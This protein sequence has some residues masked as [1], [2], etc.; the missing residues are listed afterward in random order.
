[1]DI[2][3]YTDYWYKNVTINKKLGTVTPAANRHWPLNYENAKFWA[4]FRGNNF[5]LKA[6]K[7]PFIFQTQHPWHLFPVVNEDITPPLI[8]IY[9]QYTRF[10]YLAKKQTIQILVANDPVIL[11]MMQME[12]T[13][14][15][16]LNEQK[17]VSLTLVFT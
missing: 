7:T 3:N 15:I 8:K 13:F 6:L 16:K 2:F 9:Y 5:S 1:M 14:L 17:T 11:Q 10:F 12:K 4:V